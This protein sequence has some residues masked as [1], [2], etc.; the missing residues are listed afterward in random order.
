MA[1]CST[2]A[3][4]NLL[5]ALEISEVTTAKVLAAA[6]AQRAILG[7]PA[8]ADLTESTSLKDGMATPAPARPQRIPKA[9]ALADIQAAREAL[10]E[11]ASIPNARL[12]A[13]VVA[14]LNALT[15]DPAVAAS[16]KRE[17]F[18]Y[19]RD[20]ANRGW[21]VPVLRYPMGS[22]PTHEARSGQD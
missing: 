22:R 11:I 12:V 1:Q 3:R 4:D 15:G 13:E 18:L 10:A 17:A 6:N 7:L 5:R 16:V 20:R 2:Q 9:Q 8:L 19:D 14:D 21:S